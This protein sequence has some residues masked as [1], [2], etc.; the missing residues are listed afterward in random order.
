MAS[1]KTE[2]ATVSHRFE[3]EEHGLGMMKAH[4]KSTP[5]D[6]KDVRQTG[7]IWIHAYDPD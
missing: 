7:A 3:A 4:K 2:Y 5:S 6:G 1:R